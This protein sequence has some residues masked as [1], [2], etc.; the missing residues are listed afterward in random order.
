MPTHPNCKGF[1][2][3]QFTKKRRTHGCPEITPIVSK[4]DISHVMGFAKKVYWSPNPIDISNNGRAA[5][6]L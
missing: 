3:P 6:T 5:E 1:T 4:C 2:K